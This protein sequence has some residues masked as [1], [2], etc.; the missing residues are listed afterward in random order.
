MQGHQTSGRFL[1]FIVDASILNRVKVQQQTS[2]LLQT[3]K[4]QGDRVQATLNIAGTT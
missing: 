2:G 4:V 1:G 3:P